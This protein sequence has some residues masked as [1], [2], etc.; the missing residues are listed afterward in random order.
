MPIFV[1]SAMLRAWAMGSGY[2]YQ[3]L[4]ALRA[5]HPQILAAGAAV[6]YNTAHYAAQLPTLS[7]K[8]LQS[9]TSRTIPTSQ[10][11]AQTRGLYDSRTHAL[12]TSALHKE[13][14]Q[15]HASHIMGPAIEKMIPC[16]RRY[17]HRE[18]LT[19]RRHFEAGHCSLI[20]TVGCST[21]REAP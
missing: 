10:P 15:S 18:K 19:P 17:R 8:P 3:F 14:Q 21:A 13:H 1:D 6:T 5:H 4:W 11:S 16:A 12:A 9:T 20:Q 7:D 2:S